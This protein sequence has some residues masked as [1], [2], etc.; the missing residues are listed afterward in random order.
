MTEYSAGSIVVFIETG[1]GI[2]LL[3]LSYI[4][5]FNQIYGNEFCVTLY[6]LQ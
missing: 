4:P 2:F 6:F 1:G 5:G 3:T